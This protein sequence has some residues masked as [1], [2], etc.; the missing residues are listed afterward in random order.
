MVDVG[1]LFIGVEE[2]D[3]EYKFEP[4]E[5][6]DLSGRKTE[7]TISGIYIA[8]DGYIRKLVYISK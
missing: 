2:I 1:C 8:S 7:P 5:Y 3:S 6:Y 4:K